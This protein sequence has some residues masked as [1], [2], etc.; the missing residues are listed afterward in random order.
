MSHQ[1][2]DGGSPNDK[3]LLQTNAKAAVIENV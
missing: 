3:E 1:V 2:I